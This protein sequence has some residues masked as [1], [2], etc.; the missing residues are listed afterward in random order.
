[1][2]K[3]R[4]SMDGMTHGPPLARDKGLLCREVPDGLMVYDLDHRRVH[5]L[6]QTAA[7]VW[8]HC[9]GKTGVPEMATLLQQE[10][11]LPA[12]DDVVWLAL[13][14]LAKAHLLQ[15]HLTRPTDATRTTRRAVIRK[16][17]L[18]GGLVAL[19]PLVDSLAAP[20]AAFAQSGGLE[21]DPCLLDEGNNKC[22]TCKKTGSHFNC[23]G[24]P[25]DCVGGETDECE[26]P[27][28]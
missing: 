1:M 13:D 11:N 18:A 22:G 7:L 8:Q 27:S 23:V 5:S 3:E 20:K 14:R 12:E 10:M 26:P 28:I 24:P 15:E 21:G 19:L 2:E 9:D 17:G 25:V 4:Y 6:N 16:L